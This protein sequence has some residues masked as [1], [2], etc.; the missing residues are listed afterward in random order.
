MDRQIA[1]TTIKIKDG[2]EYVSFEVDC[3]DQS[4][5]YFLVFYKHNYYIT[6][7][8][9]FIK[10]YWSPS[11][12]VYVLDRSS[13]NNI[14]MLSHKLNTRIKKNFKHKMMEWPSG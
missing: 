9:T 1:L 13:K 6:N 12:N 4:D 5:I 7:M 10:A 2:Y 11:L 8:K 3:S 14:S